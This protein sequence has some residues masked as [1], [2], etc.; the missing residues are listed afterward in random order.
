[1]AQ[2]R[3][4]RPGY[5]VIHPNR[6]K[7]SCKLTRLIVV[8]LLIASVVLMLMLTIG[9]WDKLQGLKPVNFFASLVFVLLAV[10]ILLRWAPGLLPIA[11]L[12][13]ILLL[14]TA[15]V[16]TTGLAGTSWFDRNHQ[17]FASP[18][19]LFGG[20]GLSP[21]VLGTITVLLIP[22]EIALIVFAMIGFSQGWNM[23]QEV[24]E[25]EARRRGAKT[26]AGGPNAA[27]A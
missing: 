6:Q 21:S 19:S 25:D 2:V 1:V 5:A 4:V 20:S 3:N 22:V 15:V 13:A 14:I 24:P 18:E 27:T 11:A 9:G 12:F 7:A 16:A 10:A 8:V 17:G 26:I 23:E